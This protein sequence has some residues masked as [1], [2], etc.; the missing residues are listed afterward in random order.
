MTTNR[1]IP[2]PKRVAAGKRNRQRRK[3]LTPAGRERLR[4]QALTQQ[5]WQH[6]SGPTTSAGKAQAARNGKTRQRGE[7]SVRERKGL[8]RALHLLMGGMS[9][10]RR[11]AL[12]R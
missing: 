6:A 8:L 9:A 5:P 7:Q 3:G 4:Q 10:A 11:L 2:N 12:E 1:P